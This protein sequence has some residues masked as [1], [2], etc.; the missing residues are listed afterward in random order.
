MRIQLTQE[1]KGM[2]NRLSQSNDGR[3]LTEFIERLI[4]EAVDIRNITGNVEA[5]KK[6]RE[7]A[8]Q[9]LEENFVNRIKI[10]SGQVEAPDENYE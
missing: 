6:G 10:L 8:V 5:E 4:R 7:V 1:E 3:I 2:F 9:L